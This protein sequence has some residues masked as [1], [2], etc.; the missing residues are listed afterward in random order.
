MPLASGATLGRMPA[1]KQMSFSEE[2]HTMS[3]SNEKRKFRLG[4]LCG[5]GLAAVAAAGALSYAQDQQQ[6]AAPKLGNIS[7]APPEGWHVHDR[8]RPQPP[9][10][11]PPTPSTQE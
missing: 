11:T 7:D 4:A 5:L 6:P 8:S 2:K 9:V 1:G 3:G 10:V